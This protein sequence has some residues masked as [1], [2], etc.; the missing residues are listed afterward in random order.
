MHGL[1]SVCRQGSACGSWY[2]L[3]QIQQVMASSTA[4]VVAMPEIHKILKVEKIYVNT[5]IVII[6]STQIKC[7]KRRHR[8]VQIS[9]INKQMNRLCEL[10]MVLKNVA[11]ENKK[12]SKSRISI[13]IYNK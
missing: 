12:K 8:L 7:N 3:K 5:V 11:S 9:T 4:A 10:K 2:T 13:S 6:C 1:H